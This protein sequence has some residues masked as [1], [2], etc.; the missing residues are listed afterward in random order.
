MIRILGCLVVLL[1]CTCEGTQHDFATRKLEPD[2]AVEPAGGNSS[3]GG[4]SDEAKPEGLTVTPLAIDFGPVP[5]GF[6]APARVV[7]A[8][9]GSVLLPAPELSLGGDATLD[10]SV[11]QNDCTNGIVP[12]EPCAISLVFQPG[13]IDLRSGNLHIAVGT[14]QLDVPLSGFGIPVGSAILEPAAGATTDFGAVALGGERIQSFRLLNPGQTPIDGLEA[15]LNNGAFELL[16]PASSDCVAGAEVPAGGSCD[17]RVRFAPILRGIAETTLTARSADGSGVSLN[18]EGYGSAPARLSVE[19]D[20]VDFGSVVQGARSVLELAVSNDGDQALSGVTASL[21]GPS[22]AEFS[23]VLNGCAGPLPALAVCNV[24]VAFTPSGPGARGAQLDLD[25]GAAGSATVGLAGKGVAQGD[26]ILTVGDGFSAEF[27]PALVGETLEQ[28]YRVTNPGDTAA[29]A[30]AITLNSDEFTLAAPDGEDCVPNAPLAAGASCGVRV[31][32]APLQRGQRNTTLNVASANLGAVGLSL[33]GNGL[34]PALIEVAGN[35]A[36]GAIARAESAARSFEVSNLGDQPLGAVSASIVGTHPE[37]FQ[38]AAN[39][40]APGLAFEARCGLSVSF[41]PTASGNRLATL[42]IESQ[43]GGTR[44]LSLEGTGLE[45]GALSLEAASGSSANFA[46]P[47]VLGTGQT[48]TQTFVLSN[49]GEVS[50]GAINLPPL[51]NGFQILAP[52]G[53]EC[54]SNVTQ[55]AGGTSCALRIQFTPAVRGPNAA[56]LSV[57]SQRAGGASLSLSGTGLAA[58]QL[59]VQPTQ[60]TFA[61]AVAVGQSAS[62]NLTLRNLGDVALT[63]P[64]GSLTGAAAGEFTLDTSACPP[65]LAGSGTCA[66]AVRFLPS[67]SGVR[68]ANLRLQSAPGG[69]VDVALSGNGQL[70]GALVLE[71]APGSSNFGTLVVG[72]SRVETFTLR[73]TGDLSAGRILS[74]TLGTGFSREAAAAGECNPGTTTLAGRSSCTIRVRFQ[75]QAGGDFAVSMNATSQ[76]AGSASLGLTGLAQTQARLQGAQQLSVANATVVGLQSAALNWVLTNSGDVTTQTLTLTNSNQGEFLITNGCTGV[77]ASGSSC[78]VSVRLQPTRP[79]TR[80]TVLNISAGQN[81]SASVTILGNA[82]CPTGQQD[83]GGICRLSNG[84][85]CTDSSEC[86]VDTC[87][88]VFLD[89]DNDGFGD[90]NASSTLTCGTVTGFA[91]NNDDCCDADPLANPNQTVPQPTANACGDFDYDCSGE[92]DGDDVLLSCALSPPCRSGWLS[93]PECG[94]RS[95]PGICASILGGTQCTSVGPAADN[96][97]ARRCK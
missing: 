50:S 9:R 27:G 67:V 88:A 65:S 45:P 39:D 95:A 77:L 26:L 56:T 22:S 49:L 53:D 41:R 74:V 75:P 58:A 68:S 46:N 63:T 6:A 85:P 7:L 60:L 97:R 21:S 13:E 31:L 32:F 92:A 81:V 78:S 57:S 44:E 62:A 83:D 23:I 29:D 80:S 70:P 51:G 36:F 35:P 52:T 28:G 55:L 71:A 5:L 37:D 90:E 30:L 20:R 76:S 40:C 16:E 47:L 48:Q 87:R 64:S 1:L 91:V 79:G 59:D 66:A 43:P 25:G 4:P 86:A 34:A 33:N 73:N 96:T 11:V 14:E 54:V 69:T 61:N 93:L 42:R 18:L 94:A 72:S 15:T 38:V 24:S 3:G 17:L 89:D 84:Q 2:A 8:H 10:F 19:A 12:D 82:S